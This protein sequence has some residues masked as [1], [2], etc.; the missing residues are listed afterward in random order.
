MIAPLTLLLVL[1]TNTATATPAKPNELTAAERAAG[2]HLLFDGRTLT[3]WRGLGYDTV[4]T[5][6]WVVVDGAIKKIASGNVPRVPDGRPLN[7]GDLMTV[8]TFGDFELSWEWKVTPDA[9]SGV[10]YNVSEEM[11]I[12]Q[13]GQM[14]PTAVARGAIAPN[15]SALGF[16]YQ[17]L[18]DDRHDPVGA[19][20]RSTVIFRGNHGEHW[21]NGQKI[22]EFELGTA[23]MDSLLAASK[24]RSIPG[25]GD[26]RKGH[27]VLQDHG[28]E[29][30]FRSVKVRSL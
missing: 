8:D 7:G 4:P 9:N 27:I 5:G 3:G 19:W 10:K 26:R 22:V 12:A 28:D 21:L 14:T 23:R 30:Y 6:H 17:M 13:N 29:V 25:F 15:H 20:N 2:W 16:E 1:Q 11:S 24:Y 18:D